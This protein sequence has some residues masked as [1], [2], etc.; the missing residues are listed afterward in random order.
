MPARKGSARSRCSSPRRGCTRRRARLLGRWPSS[1]AAGSRTGPRTRAPPGR[2]YRWWRGG[3]THSAT[4]PADGGGN[5][6]AFGIAAHP[7]WPTAPT[8]TTRTVAG[9]VEQ[10]MNDAT[11]CRFSLRNIQRRTR[12][13]RRPLRATADVRAGRSGAGR[14]AGV[15]G[16]PVV[17]A[18]C[19][20]W[21]VFPT[22]ENPRFR[23]FVRWHRGSQYR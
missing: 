9:S 16:E 21:L 1:S 2:S 8:I 6:H 15:A 17:A 4:A 7:Q 11:G 3:V 22:E 19:A 18:R 12:S 14:A 5:G 23:R 20:L 10:T 13:Y